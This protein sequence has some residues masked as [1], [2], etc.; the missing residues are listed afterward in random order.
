MNISNLRGSRATVMGLGL[1]GGGVA[2]AR[3]LAKRGAKVLVTDLRTP[4]ILKDSIAALD[5]LPIEFRLGEHRDDDF[6]NTDLVVANPAVAPSSKYLTIAR[7]ADVKITSEL[8]LFLHACPSKEILA[9]TGTN[10]KTSVT[11]LA[12]EM[13]KL[14]KPRVF[15]GGNIGKSL[16]DCLDD[17]QQNDVIVLEVSSF[18]LEVLDP[19]KPWPRVAAV[20]N[21]SPD[22]LDRHGTMELYCSAKR[23]IVEFQD[24]ACDAIINSSDPVV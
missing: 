3:F 20:T 16:L 11:T 12:G 2:T 4:D 18:Q 1:F 9:I 21:I 24:S 7:D 17:L 6:K 8:D 23:R 15:I 10:G 14:S 22:H 13:L 5:G 19:P